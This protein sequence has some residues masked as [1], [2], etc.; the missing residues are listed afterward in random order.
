MAAILAGV[1]LL[2]A[3][4][5]EADYPEQ[6]IHLVVPWRAGGGTD[7]IA[8]ALAAAMEEVSGQSVVVENV[9]GGARVPGT[10][11]VVEA[12]PD[13]YR[14]LLNG[15]SDISSSMVF[16]DVPF[17]LDDFVCIGGVYQTPVWILS[18]RDQGF[19]S[20]DDLVAAAKEEPGKLTIGVTALKTPDETLAKLLSEKHGIDVRI[21][22]FDGGAALKKALLGNQVS[23]G[24]LYVPV[25]LPEIESGAVDLLVAGGS[26][27]NVNYPPI[28]NTKTPA[29]YGV[30]IVIGSFRGVLMP[31]GVPESVR[32]A[33][34]ELVQK[35]V[36]SESYKAFG[37]KFGVAPEW[38]PGQR[39]CDFI[40]EEMRVFESVNN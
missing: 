27:Q 14:M 28:R 15:S 38:L 39:Y 18:H 30:D 25:M 17:K 7:S 34:V 23:A 10:M 2:P 12:K 13:G 37:E 35:A 32:K 22:P 16:R 6:T 8:R 3:G 11:S 29:D 1:L 4:P 40:A 19:K 26:L 31:K 33:A 36:E 9:S 24:V 20:F 5:A 21:I